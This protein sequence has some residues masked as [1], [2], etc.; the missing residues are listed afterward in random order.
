M[1]LVDP[2]TAVI[3]AFC[4]LG[5]M[6]YKRINLGIALNATAIILALL[7][8]DWGEIPKIIYASVNPSAL[9]GQLAISVVIATF[10]IMWLSELYKKTSVIRD[11]SESLSRIVKNS[12]IVLSVLPTILGLLPV[13]GGALMSAPIVELEAEKLKM[14]AE[15]KAYVNVWFRHLIPPI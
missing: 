8:L 9:E 3:I 6:L 2:L 7:A 14:K 1:G 13:A 12:K 11:L 5:V 15:K 4:F 10:R